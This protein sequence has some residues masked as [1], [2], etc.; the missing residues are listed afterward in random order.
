MI[1]DLGGKGKKPTDNLPGLGSLLINAPKRITSH[2]INYAAL[3]L[4]PYYPSQKASSILSHRQSNGNTY[5]E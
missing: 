4:L 1:I 5:S 3:G 2:V